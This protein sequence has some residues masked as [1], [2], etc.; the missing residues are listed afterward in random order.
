MSCRASGGLLCRDPAAA[1]GLAPVKTRG[2]WRRRLGSV[3]TPRD[4]AAGRIEEAARTSPLTPRHTPICHSEGGAARNH[5]SPDTVAP[6]E[7]STVSHFRARR[8]ASSPAASAHAAAGAICRPI[9]RIR[10]VVSSL[11]RRGLGC[12][13]VH[14]VRSLGMTDRA[15]GAVSW[16]AG[17]SRAPPICHSEG[18]AAR[19]HPSPDI[20]APTEESTVGHFRACRRASSP[21]ASALAAAGAV[22][23][24]SHEDPDGRFLSRAQSIRCGR[25]H[26]VRSLGMTDLCAEMREEYADRC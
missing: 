10:T 14:V 1:A 15:H 24:S 2:R 19:N 6:T 23:P 25:V 16:E 11:G 18:G 3:L 4:H 7:E 22:R 5:A 13:R 20:L 8:R 9:T 17:Q 12:G 21:A 26:E